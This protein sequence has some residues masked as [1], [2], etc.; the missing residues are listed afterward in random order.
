MIEYV[1][2]F[3]GWLALVAIVTGVR[4]LRRRGRREWAERAL[5]SLGLVSD[6]VVGSDPEVTVYVE[7]DQSLSFTT[8]PPYDVW[9]VPDREAAWG[10]RVGGPPNP[11]TRAAVEGALA[12]GVRIDALGVWAK[13]P[14]HSELPPAERLAVVV[15]TWRALAR[16]TIDELMW[17][18]DD[19]ESPTH[20]RALLAA[21]RRLD[22]DR[23]P[24]LVA[25]RWESASPAARAELAA[26]VGDL[27]A[28]GSLAADKYAPWPATDAAAEHLAAL[29]GLDRLRPRLGEL[30]AARSWLRGL[31]TLPDEL[32]T[33]E[34]LFAHQLDELHPVLH[35]AV[36]ARVAGR[37]HDEAVLLRALGWPEARP[38]AIRALTAFGTVAAVPALRA[39]EDTAAAVRAIQHRATGE[40][41]GVALAEPVGGAVSLAA[42]DRR[43]RVSE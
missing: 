13:L 30:R 21:L 2:L 19:V 1:C 4:A 32:L 15:N 18:L 9:L 43:G 34:A 31:A 20:L 26:I 24:A 14:C 17:A 33:L 37:S 36:A 7:P 29:G 35:G 8:A 23:L 41:G 12:H 40:R 6:G 16:P 10:A 42:A 5:E 28:L 39:L 38:A 3:G 25:A 22:P 27:E 11:V